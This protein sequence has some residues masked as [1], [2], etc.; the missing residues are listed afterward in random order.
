MV[1][2]LQF[3]GIGLLV[4]GGCGLAAYSLLRQG[5]RFMQRADNALAGARA[6][7]EVAALVHLLVAQ[8]WQVEHNLALQWGDADVVLQSPQGYSFVVDV[9]SHQGSIV[10]EGDSLKRRLGN[11]TYEFQEGDLLKKARGQ[12]F[13]I[14]NRKQVK[15]VVPLL[16]FTQAKVQLKQQPIQGV[17]ITS[18]QNLVDTLV[19]LDYELSIADRF[20]ES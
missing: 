13:E 11:Q 16:C 18:K 19:S 15:W 20:P 8:G 14:Q 9:K 2:S 1:P 4:Y 12:A 3:S 5:K 17:Y 6:E 7:G 10:L